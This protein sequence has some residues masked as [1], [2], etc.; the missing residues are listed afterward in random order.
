[1][2]LGHL[3]RKKLIGYLPKGGEIVEIGVATGAFSTEI[4]SVAEP[5][6]LHLIDPW[7][8]QVRADYVK[9]G[10]NVSDAEHLDRYR[11]ILTGFAP[12]IATGKVKV[13]RGYSTR[14]APSFADGQFDWIYLDALHSRR[15]V[16]ADLKAYH[17][18]VK[19]EGFL[20]GHDYTNQALTQ[21]LDFGVV[22]AVDAFVTAHPEWTFLALT[23]EMYP[24]YVLTRTP[25][26]AAAT[27]LVLQ[28]LT[29]NSVVEIRDHPIGSRF[30]HVSYMLDGRLVAVVPSF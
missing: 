10:N 2:Y 8:H 11:T 12:Q 21:K 29:Q 28:L 17:S 14:L 15:A 9:D 7:E 25:Q 26:S 22:D 4:L 20:L 30:R 3:S 6:C 13:H 18:K 24:T 23:A 27:A 19:P 1:M 5:D 16:A